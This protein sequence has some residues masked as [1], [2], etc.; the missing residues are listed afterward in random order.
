MA[1]LVVEDEAGITAFLRRG[2]ESA[3]FAVLSESGGRAGALAAQREDVELVILDLGLPD[4]PGEQ[5]LARIRA[6]RPAL[7]VIVLTAKDAVADRVAN[8]EAGADD[9]VVKP[10]SFT[11]LLARVRARLRQPAQPS[12]VV[13]SAGG[14][15]LDVRTRRVRVLDEHGAAGREVALSSREFALLETLLRHPGQVLSQVQLLDRVWGY[16][17]D[18]ASNVVETC[19][20][21]VR[22][23]VGAERIET[24]RGAGYRLVA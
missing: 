13:L 14:L 21:H 12:S 18:G 16:D 11:E 22:R 3:G 9:Y 4:L 8:L 20:R 10:F 24:V 19:V 17:F 1:V 6:A 7:P 23:K 2:L 15:T 5:V